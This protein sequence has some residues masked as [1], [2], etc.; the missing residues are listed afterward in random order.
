MRSTIRKFGPAAVAAVAIAGAIATGTAFADAAGR[1]TDV[2]PPSSGRTLTVGP[3]GQYDTIQAAAD[4]AQPGDNVAIEP[5]EYD[6]GLTVNNSGSDGKY[7]TFYGDG[8]AAVI[9]GD[10][11]GDD[12][13]LAIGD[14]SWLRFIDVTSKGS[15]GF[16]VRANGAHDLVFQNF[17]VDGSQ[18]GGLVLLGTQNILVDGCDIHDTNGRGTSADQ[19]AMSLG[20]GSSNIEVK[21]CEVHDNGEEGI[22]VKYDDD[23]QAKIH[24]NVVT[25]NR[26]PNIY[27]DS[28]SNVEVYNNVSTGT[29]NETKAGI[30]LAVEDYSS[31]HKLDNVKIYNNVSYG[32][33]QAG[34]GFWV[35]S[36]GTMSNIQVVNNTF[37][38]ND[39][40]AVAFDADQ[41]GGD[42]VLRNNVFG[43]GDVSNDD[44]AA[45]H[46]VS[47][48]PGFVDPGSGD[49][50]LKDGSAAIDAGSKTGAPAFDRD[51]KP[52]PAGDGFDIGAYER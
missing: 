37:F 21:N 26:G 50:H 25:G 12:G 44:F 4:E 14:S 19:E 52:R 28:S 15:N 6:G 18:D 8:G 7:I 16:G 11:G 9:T 32:N 24:D 13:L 5:G 2:P 27:V 36:S 1:P 29:T 35:E 42:N 20:E 47:G 30:G 17:G 10:G 38:G 40:G 3:N 34:L 31:S 39:R 22:D 49:F 23:A 45:D 46:N 33:A 41:F 48:D 43:E 51:N